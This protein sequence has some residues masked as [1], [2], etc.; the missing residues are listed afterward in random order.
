M[1]R[2]YGTSP[3]I[4]EFPNSRV[5]AFPRYRGD[6]TADVVIVGGG[7][8]G[9][10]FAYACAVA[11]LDTVLLEQ[12][13]IG[14]GRSGRSAGLMSPEPG[15][16][17]RDIS[18]AYGLKAAR[19]VFEMW[20]R[21]AL[22]GAALIRRLGIKCQLAPR[23]ELVVAGGDDERLLRREYDARRAAGLGVAWL[24]RKQIQARTGLDGAGG[25]KSSDAFAVDPYRACIGLAVEASRRGITFFE[26]SAVRKVRFTRKFADVMCENGTI[27]TRK[28]IVATGT[29]TAEFKSLQR[30]LDRREAYLVMTEILPAIMRRQLGDSKIVLRD[31]QQPPNVISHTHDERL[32]VEGGDQKETPVRTRPAVLVQRTGQ[33]MYE[34]LKKYP[35]ISGLQPDYG[36]EV[37]YGQTADG[38]MYIGPH[39]NYPHH[40]FALGGSAASITG[41]FVAAR[42]LARAVQDAT[43]KSD[44][45]FAWTR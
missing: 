30:H 26:H 20:R 32:I 9:C 17:F 31:V 8:T 36:W 44:Q 19:R 15:P 33:L 24:T 41:A 1:A 45:V 37:V 25:M 40:V 12:D 2:R 22:D 23:E 4:H 39:R 34:A 18:G 11:G 7:L 14:R 10:A 43:E 6:R 42:L 29:A 3:W 21:G 27:R 13:R 16:S 35:V 38:L 5:P 28:V